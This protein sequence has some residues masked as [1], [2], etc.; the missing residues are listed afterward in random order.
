MGTSGMAIMSHHAWIIV[1]I[2][3]LAGLAGFIIFW[4]GMTVG[5][6]WWHGEKLGRLDEMTIGVLV[7]AIATA[8]LALL[9]IPNYF[10]TGLQLSFNAVQWS[11]RTAGIVIALVVVHMVGYGLL[12]AFTWNRYTAPMFIA[13][14][15][16][17]HVLWIMIAWSVGWF[18]LV[19]A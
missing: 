8:L 11:F 14:L 6:K 17:W 18:S 16:L 3:E 7:N 13:Y 19:L 15:V 2:I 1:L 9:A 5:L 4:W 12:I 10:F